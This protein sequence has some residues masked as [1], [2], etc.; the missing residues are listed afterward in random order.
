MNRKGGVG[1]S[2]VVAQLSAVTAET[3]GADPETGAPSVAALSADPQGSL[4]FWMNRVDK[5]PFDYMQ[6]ELDGHSASPVPGM[7]RHLIPSPS[8]DLGPTVLLGLDQEPVPV[9]GSAPANFVKTLD[10]INYLREL[11]YQHVFVDTPG[12]M[13]L[14]NDKALRKD[15]WTAVLMRALF[16]Q[17]H[18]VIV[19]M[20]S[21][22]MSWEP[23]FETIE[24]VLKPLGAKFIV[25]VNNWEPRDGSH[26]KHPDR[27]AAITFIDDNGWPRANSTIR[28]FK[29]HSNASMYGI[30]CTQY[31]QNRME[32]NAALDFYRLGLELGISLLGPRV[33]EMEQVLA[34]RVQQRRPRNMKA[35]KS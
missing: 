15:S 19:P 27:D 16:K 12:W 18:T 33:Q 1:K 13:E 35:G 31:K 10:D 26:E 22:P 2:T 28:H 9:P 20:E 7:P 29:V 17:A 30:L 25:V 23:T 34:N 14:T 32:L 21:E 4:G 24:Y 5:K 6:L 3:L 11:P 8:L